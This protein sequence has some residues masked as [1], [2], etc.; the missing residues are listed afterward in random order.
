MP[1]SPNNASQQRP[2]GSPAGQ[3]AQLWG[4]VTLPDSQRRGGYQAV[5]ADRLHL[6]RSERPAGF[7]DCGPK[8]RYRLTIS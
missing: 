3:Q 2:S 1:I 5:L 6:A 7:T 8:R 4:A